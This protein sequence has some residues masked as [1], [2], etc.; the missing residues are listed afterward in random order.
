MANLIQVT[1]GI[2]TKNSKSFAYDEAPYIVNHGVPG[3]VAA[4]TVSPIVWPNGTSKLTFFCQKQLKSLTIV[5]LTAPT[6]ASENWNGTLTTLWPVNFNGVLNPTGTYT[7]VACAFGAPGVTGTLTSSGLQTIAVFTGTLGSF[8]PNLGTQAINNPYVSVLGGGTCTVAC[9]G[10]SG[11]WT[12]GNY[13]FPTG[14]GGGL[15]CNPGD[16]LTLAKGTDS[17]AIYSVVAEFSFTPGS[18]FSI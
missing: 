12:V 11:T 10:P 16:V 5:P 17:V 2:P 18:T 7:Q 8:P 4:A 14:P 9:S 3:S 13:V 1:Q 15:T 6:P